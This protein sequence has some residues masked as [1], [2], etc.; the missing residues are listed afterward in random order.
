MSLFLLSVF[1]G[2]L[3]EDLLEILLSKLTCKKEETR[4]LITTEEIQIFFLI[5]S[6]I[7]LLRIALCLI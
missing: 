5:A 3:I 4:W 6:S 1:S 2:Q 7:C